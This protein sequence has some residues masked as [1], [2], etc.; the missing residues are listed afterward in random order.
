MPGVPFG[1]VAEQRLLSCQQGFW[2]SRVWGFWRVS[3]PESVVTPRTLGSC[4]GGPRTCESPKSRLPRLPRGLFLA[5]LFG[6]FPF[7]VGWCP[8]FLT[9]HLAFALGLCLLRTFNRC[10]AAR[11]FF[12]PKFR[13]GIRRSY[14]T[15]V[16]SL[17]L[18]RTRL[19][20]CF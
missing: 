9:Q 13:A 17:E 12:L 8:G 11:G 18:T 1:G 15:L 5:L 14:S 3:E 19:S 4:R 16:E 2:R 6:T 7:L 20:F 10:L